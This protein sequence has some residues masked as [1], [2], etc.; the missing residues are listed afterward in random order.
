MDFKTLNLLSKKNNKSPAP[1]LC[2]Q[3]LINETSRSQLGISPSMSNLGD[4]DETYFKIP[5]VLNNFSNINNNQSRASILTTNNAK[6]SVFIQPIRGTSVQD[7]HTLRNRDHEILNSS[8]DEY[9]G[10]ND[11][12]GGQSI[13]D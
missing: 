5:G 3:M 2:K 13:D 6:T 8:D 4:G 11:R 1:E 10:P 7:K 9:N 12:M